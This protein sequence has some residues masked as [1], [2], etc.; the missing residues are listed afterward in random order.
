MSTFIELQSFMRDAATWPNPAEYTVQASQIFSWFQPPRQVSSYPQK[1]NTRTNEFVA[2]VNVVSVLIPHGQQKHQDASPSWQTTGSPYQPLLTSNAAPGQNLPTGFTSN[3]YD[4]LTAQRLYLDIHSIR[5]DNDKLMQSMERTVDNVRSTTCLNSLGSTVTVLSTFPTPISDA[6]FT[7]TFNKVQAT[8]DGLANATTT[9][10]KAAAPLW[11]SYMAS[12]EQTMRFSRDSELYVRIYDPNV[13]INQNDPSSTTGPV[14]LAAGPA[15][16]LYGPNAYDIYGG[17]YTSSTSNG[18]WTEALS[19]STIGGNKFN[20]LPIDYSPP[21][22]S[23][24]PGPNANALLLNY[25]TFITLQIT[26]YIR[27]NTFSNHLSDLD[28]PS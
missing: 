1:I 2:T 4:P 19:T 27:D 17:V 3:Q 5:Y 7:L 16:D 18:S 21:S 15:T 25:Q 11:A 26:P 12:P 8:S 28:N 24:A 13:V 22:G 10:G 6:K 14:R 9:G 20:T 23:G